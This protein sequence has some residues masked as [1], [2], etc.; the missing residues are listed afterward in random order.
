[1]EILKDIIDDGD[2]S[3][4]FDMCKCS[5]CGWKGEI[6]DCETEQEQDGFEG[7]PYT[8]HIC[9]V[10]EDGGCIDDYW[11]SDEMAESYFR[12]KGGL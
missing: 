1:M 10:C 7:T 5:N 4:K 12:K 2:D 3:I 6:S 8:I 11:L 9:P